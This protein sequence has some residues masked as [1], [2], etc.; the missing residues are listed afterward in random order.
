VS[1]GRYALIVSG[2]V[3]GSLA[4]VV[5][6]PSLDASS[7]GAVALGG[8]IA[9]LNSLA[10]YG[11]VLWAAPR[12]TVAFMRAILGGMVGRMALVLG[13]VVAAML[14]LD[15]PRLPFTVSL[16]T[17]FVLLLVFE[18]SVV[19]RRTSRAAVAR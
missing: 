11:L 7:R 12:S 9:G 19:H 18:L 8:I 1:F 14:V 17:Y 2:L 13:A 3:V 6:L 15:I 10:A 4:V 5:R 16:L